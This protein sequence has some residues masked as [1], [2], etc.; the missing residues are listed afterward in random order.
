MLTKKINNAIHK[1]IRER[2]D[3]DK[4]IKNVEL[5]IKPKQLWLVYF[6]KATE[7]KYQKQRKCSPQNTPKHLAN[8][9]L[10]LLKFGLHHSFPPSGIYKT[11]VFV[12]FEMMHRFLLENLKNATDK[13]VF[14]SELSYLANSYVRNYQS[15]RS[16][17]RKHG[18]LKK[19]MIRVL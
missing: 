5:Q 17:I 8:Q 10:D 4:K 2:N 1:R 13:S 16:T 11:D 12:S 7:R 19:L 14:K 3:F 15:S 9:E 18:I 6:S